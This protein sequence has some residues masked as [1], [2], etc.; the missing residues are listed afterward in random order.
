MYRPYV[1]AGDFVEKGTV[2]A[3]ISSPFGD[4]EKEIKAP[5]SGYIICINHAPIVNQGDAIV[6]ITR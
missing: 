1:T 2:V 4:F 3:S 5:S 6:H